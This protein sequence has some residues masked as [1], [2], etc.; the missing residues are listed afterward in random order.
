MSGFFLYR[1]T[2]KLEPEKI[3]DFFER[4]GSG[5]FKQ[6]SVGDYNLLLFSKSL[7]D[8][9]NY[10]ELEDGSFIAGIGTFVYKGYDPEV[11]LKLF[12]NDFVSGNVAEE[13]T[14]GSFCLLIYEKKDNKFT[15]ILD[16]SRLC[17]I[18]S[19][20]DKSIISSSFLA[21]VEFSKSK[22]RLDTQS[23][24]EQLLIGYIIPPYTL[25]EKI[26]FITDEEF[27]NDSVSVHIRK[28]LP[29]YKFDCRNVKECLNEGKLLLEEYAIRIERSV[30]KYGL[31]M[32]LSGGYD[33][34]LLLAAFQ[35]YKEKF[36][37]YSYGGKGHQEELKV[38]N[39]LSKEL[40][41]SVRIT[42]T[43]SS[44]E[45]NEEELS[46]NLMD[47]LYFY[48]GRPNRSMGSYNDVHTAKF[49]KKL[50]GELP[51]LEISGLG[52]ELLRNF[53]FLFHRNRVRFYDWFILY[54]LQMGELYITGKKRLLDFMKKFSLR[55]KRFL[56]EEVDPAGFSDIL[57]L[58]RFYS[59][60]WTPF[61][62]GVKN[63][64]ENK[65]IFFLTPFAEI[66]FRKFSRHVL[67]C[68]GMKKDFEAGLIKIFDEN[69]ARIDSVYGFNFQKS[70]KSLV[71]KQSL[72][73]RA[74][75]KLK[76]IAGIVKSRGKNSR[77]AGLARFPL[78]KDSLRIIEDIPQ[79]GNFL[80]SVLSTQEGFDRAVYIG[81][82]LTTYSHKIDWSV[83]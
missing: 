7:L 42:E 25:F 34:R 47:S 56:M 52:G 4:G 63:N 71:W 14:T 16:P 75:I 20:Y 11:S 57:W 23:L 62:R 13:D 5:T 35:R 3:G 74:P 76:A 36:V 82:F 39:K 70:F 72:K 60:V 46:R 59:D 51:R 10:I 15:I 45:L 55:I 33:S 49:R 78:I 50:L 8:Y 77:V 22:L 73:L 41:V 18:F 24:M 40:K 29:D 43:R 38:V 17:H 48:D 79:I 28:L 64:V 19:N 67:I 6:F 81:F 61:A 80:D 9:K 1:L 37:L 21:I 54:L 83:T 53:N 26:H 69:L 12:F 58:H 66:L 30:M 65:L 44:Y 68:C 2:E 32:G 27:I 31:T